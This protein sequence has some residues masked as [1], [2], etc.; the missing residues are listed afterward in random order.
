NPLLWVADDI[1]VSPDARF[2]LN[3]TGGTGYIIQFYNAT[4]KLDINDPRSFLITTNSNTPMFYWP[5]A[6]T[7]NLNAQMVNYWD[8]VGTIDRTDLASQSFSLPNGEN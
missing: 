2:I 5:Y 7:F 4:A 1:T 8:T 3:K 6:N